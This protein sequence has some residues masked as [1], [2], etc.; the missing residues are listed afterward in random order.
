MYLHLT[1]EELVNKLWTSNARDF[2]KFLME[3][4]LALKPDELDFSDIPSGI[5]RREDGEDLIRNRKGVFNFVD[6][7]GTGQSSIAW[8]FAGTSWWIQVLDIRY[9]SVPLKEAKRFQTTKGGKRIA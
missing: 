9:N 5:Y 8:A 6:A 7:H 3:E 2:V 1:E 4:G